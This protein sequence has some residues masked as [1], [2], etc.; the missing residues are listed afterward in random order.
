MRGIAKY[1]PTIV[2]FVCST[3]ELSCMAT[4]IELTTSV[5]NEHV[6]VGEPIVVRIRLSNSGHN[7]EELN[8][9]A[10]GNEAFNIKVMD[11]SNQ[12]VCEVVGATSREGTTF[13]ATPMIRPGG[14]IIKTFVLDKWCQNMLPRG[15]YNIETQYRD[16]KN[17]SLVLHGKAKFDISSAN[18]MQTDLWL[19]ATYERIAERPPSD[20]L[21]VLVQEMAYCH[22]PQSVS[23]MEKLLMLPDSQIGELEMGEMV[24][25]LGRIGSLEA[26]RILVRVIG[27]ESRGTWLGQISRQTAYQLYNKVK[28]ERGQADIANELKKVIDMK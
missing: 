8:F 4:G 9:G 7:D 20:E 19:S 16:K 21:R 15:A 12:T 27:R 25:G 24:V 6:I 2:Y 11:A 17:T 10:E 18:V 13:I 22:F 26:A 28:A 1:C 3:A 14:K 5:K 23:Y